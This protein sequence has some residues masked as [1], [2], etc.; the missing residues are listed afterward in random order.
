[1][2]AREREPGGRE[3]RPI[4]PGAQALS[5][6]SPRPR[7]RFRAQNLLLAL[8]ADFFFGTLSSNWCRLVDEMRQVWAGKAFAP[9][10]DLGERKNF[11]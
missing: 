6:A 4:A 7:G 8:E 10:I 1:M 9:Y 5:G 11:W 2:C 3:A